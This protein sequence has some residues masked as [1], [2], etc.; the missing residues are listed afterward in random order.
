MADS[1]AGLAGAGGV[2]RLRGQRDRARPGLPAGCAAG[3]SGAVAAEEPRRRLPPQPP[4]LVR[5][6]VLGV[7]GRPFRGSSPEAKRTR[8]DVRD[9][10]ARRGVRAFVH[11][12]DALGI[13]AARRSAGNPSAPSPPVAAGAFTW[14]GRNAGPGIE[15]HRRQPVH[16]VHASHLHGHRWRSGSSRSPIPACSCLEREPPRGRCRLC[17][18][19]PYC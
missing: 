1:A 5:A 10:V 4:L 13:P 11:R 12:G 6:G 7:T 15:R 16:R 3:F 8:D 2:C 17:C 18:S 19:C 9:V 14:R